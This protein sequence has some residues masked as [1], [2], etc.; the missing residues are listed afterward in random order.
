MSY[1]HDYWDDKDYASFYCL[2][3]GKLLGNVAIWQS[4]SVAIQK[5]RD[6]LNGHCP[7]CGK[8]LNTEA[9]NH[10]EIF[11]WL[12]TIHWHLSI[13]KRLWQSYRSFSKI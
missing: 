11:Y 13:F 4:K 8:V 12:K 10:P 9:V 5:L 1:D 2:K 7:R 3:C 6:S